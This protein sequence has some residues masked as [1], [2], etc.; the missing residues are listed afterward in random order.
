M[1]GSETPT[2]IEA[3]TF[4]HRDGRQSDVAAGIA[5][6]TMRMLVQL[7]FAPVMELSL[8]NNRRADIA[9]V[10]IKGEIWIIEVKSCLADYRADGKWPDYSD[11]CDRFFFAVD[12]EFPIDVIPQDTGLILADRFGAEIVRDSPED[13]L[14][15]ARRKALTLRF[16]RVTSQRLH[17][18]LD[19]AQKMQ[20][21]F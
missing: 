10:G 21:Q 20:T 12:A 5:R 8:A 14:S 16:A 19:P 9:A 7:G 15:G 4:A 6:G 2:G 11:Y 13:R 3:Q 18:L 1:S 17:G